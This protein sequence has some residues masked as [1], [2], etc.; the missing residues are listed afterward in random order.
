MWPVF[1]KAMGEHIDSLKKLVEGS[2]AG[3]FSR[4]SATTDAMV[5]NLCKR[6]MV[7]FGAFVSLTMQE[8]ETMIFSNLMRL[9]HELMKLITKHTE[10][11]RDPVARCTSQS[12]IYDVLLRGLTG[13]L[14]SAHPKSQ[15]ENAHWANLQEEARRKILSNQASR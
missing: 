4:T 15:Q 9:R 14:F 12:K 5:T 7:I 11:I 6:Y 13:T 10:R 3:Y 1:Q 2:S 8:D